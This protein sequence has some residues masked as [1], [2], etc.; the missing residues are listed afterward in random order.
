MIG[1]CRDGDDAGICIKAEGARGDSFGCADRWLDDTGLTP[2]GTEW[3]YIYGP[4][5]DESENILFLFQDGRLVWVWG[6][7]P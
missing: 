6:L 1:R 2:N 4:M 7:F 3:V 5:S